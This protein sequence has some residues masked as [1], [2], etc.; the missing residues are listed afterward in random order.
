MEQTKEIN[1]DAEVAAS[2]KLR[3]SNYDQRMQ[4]S[5]SHR[6]FY[7]VDKIVICPSS[8]NH[9]IQG[10]QFS[11]DKYE[12]ADSGYYEFANVNLDN[13]FDLELSIIGQERGACFSFKLT[14]DDYV[15]GAT[16]W[17]SEQDELIRGLAF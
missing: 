10:V 1:A 5:N 7:H 4:I 3:A 8:D 6:P 9:A 12:R 2:G 11:I 16:V 14:E 13:L 15:I 17:Y